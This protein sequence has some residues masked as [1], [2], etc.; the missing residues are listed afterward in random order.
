MATDVWPV[1]GK[2]VGKTDRTGEIGKSNNLSGIACATATGFPRI[3]LLA[4]DET[5][6]VQI[7]VVK[8]EEVVAGD[9]IRLIY[10]SH[11]EKLLELDAEGVAY[12]DGYFYVI[13][14]HG[15]PRH[16]AGE[17]KK[18]K[19]KNDAK[20]EASRHLLRLRFDPDAVDGDG[21]LRGAVEIKPCTELPRFIKAEPALAP[22]FDGKLKDKGLTIEGVAVRDGRLYAGMREPLLD[23]GNAA[24]LSVPLDVLFDGKPGKGQLHRVDLDGR[25]VRDLAAFGGGFLVLA[26]P[27]L[28]PPNDEVNDGDYSVI[29]W[30]GSNQRKLLG[31]LESYGNG[32]KPEALLPLD[33]RGG[34]LRLL[35]LFDGPEE[36]GPRLIETRP[37]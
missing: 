2:V 36:G 22:S 17:T 7:V 5:Q 26:G 23:D 35:V 3:G 6:G 13:G 33:L 20:A 37:P 12:A 29:W 1:K 31:D 11:G 32:V 30:N 14:S 8:D 15:R 28:D 25:G 24:I 18:D 21:R 9:F 27:V 19:K 4:D 10:N 34:R 16:E